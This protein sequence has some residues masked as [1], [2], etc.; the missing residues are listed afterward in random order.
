MLQGQGATSAVDYCIYL[1]VVEIYFQMHISEV[2]IEGKWQALLV[3]EA[4]VKEKCE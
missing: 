1:P 2:H 4:E 3:H